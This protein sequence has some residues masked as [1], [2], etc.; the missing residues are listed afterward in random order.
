M[1]FI[2]LSKQNIKNGP[3]ITAI[4]VAAGISLGGTINLPIVS[5]VKINNAPAS[6]ENGIN[7]L[8]SEPTNCLE[9]CGTSNPTKQ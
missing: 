6:A 4:I 3:P 1:N 2:T 5:A 8:W 9:I 7:T